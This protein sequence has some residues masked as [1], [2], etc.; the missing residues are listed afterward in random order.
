MAHLPRPGEKESGPHPNSDEG[1]EEANG[2]PTTI[3]LGQENNEDKVHFSNAWKRN[4]S[5]M[6]SSSDNLAMAGG[7]TSSAPNPVCIGKAQPS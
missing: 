5:A 6:S 1:W 7:A 2:S 4:D 3:R